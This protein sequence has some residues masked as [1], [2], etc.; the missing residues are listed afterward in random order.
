MALIARGD[1]VGHGSKRCLKGLRLN[2]TRPASQDIVDRGERVHNG[3]HTTKYTYTEPLS[4]IGRC[5]I[6]LKRYVNGEFVRW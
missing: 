4:S 3:L 2:I 1:V 5:I 6:S